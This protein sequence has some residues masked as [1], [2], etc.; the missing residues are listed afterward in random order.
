MIRGACF[1]GPDDHDHLVLDPSVIRFADHH[2]EEDD[3]GGGAGPQEEDD[4]RSLAWGYDNVEL[5]TVG[6]DVG[7]STSHLLFARLHLQR[8]AQT[9]S[10]RFAVVRRDVLHRSPILLTPYRPDGLIDVEALDRFVHQAYADAGL[11]PEE[12][13]TGAV[14]LTGAALERANARAVAELFAAEGGKFVCAS[15]GHNL[16]ALLA[17]HGSGAV[18]LSH[19]MGDT[20][21]HV[22]VGG[23]TSK[24]SLVHDGDVLETAA[25]GVGGRL[26]AV[27]DEERVV[28]IEHAGQSVAERL[29]IRLALGER[30]S[31]ADRRR[32]ADLLVNVLLEVARGEIRSDLARELL[33][34]EPL[35]LS[36]PP[37]AMSFSGGVSEYVYGRE[38]AGYGDLALDLAAA[39][40]EARERGKLPAP[41][42]SLGEGIRATVIGASQFSVQLSGN[43]LHISNPSVLPLRNLPVVYSRLP[44]G[45]LDQQGVADA[46]AQ[47]FRRLDLTEGEAPVALAIPWKGEPY[48]AT[49]RALAG[50]IAAAVP[51]SV[52]AGFPL[53]VALDGDVG[54]SLGGILE[55]EFGVS[56][57]LVS[58][59]GLQLLELDYVDIGEV[60][61]PANVVPV[62]V[63]SLAFP[64]PNGA[65]GAPQVHTPEALLRA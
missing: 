43:T 39:L 28:R 35:T 34:T 62:V 17:A 10:S 31:A 30:L 16:E 6:V 1:H 25:V 3:L 27:D 36:R 38:T 46:I 41:V 8:L 48:Y 7:S 37:A 61:Q 19:Q 44:E 60:I 59:D 63:K 23:G 42:V 54:R 51:H 64:S 14:I 32:M 24:L 40:H 65:A 52:R 15:A 9:L 20:V 29:G 55:E 18:A 4:Q 22:D 53:V 26:V 49:L 56:A 11:R 2:S 33:L 13:D 21:L 57:D 45:E 47:A 5:T 12:I 58:I 50:G